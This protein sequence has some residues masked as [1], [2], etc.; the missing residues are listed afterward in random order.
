RGATPAGAAWLAGQFAAAIVARPGDTDGLPAPAEAE[1]L[2]AAA[3]TTHPSARV[4]S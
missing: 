4:P 3:L 1:A 2:L